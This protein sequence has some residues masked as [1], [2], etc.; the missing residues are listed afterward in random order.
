[1]TYA[2]R[3]FLLKYFHIATDED[4]IDNEQRKKTEPVKE[5]PIATQKNMDS[6]K[7]KNATIEQIENIYQVSDELKKYYECL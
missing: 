1:M 6:A 3:Y 5:K 7:L 4:D 2:E